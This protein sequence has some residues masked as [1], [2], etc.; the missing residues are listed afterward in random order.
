MS[1]TARAPRVKLVITEE[2]IAAAVPRDSNHCM[3]ADA[4]KVARPDA[5]AVS[6]DLATIRFTDP[7]KGLRYTYMTPRIAQVCL[8]NFDREIKPVP[9]DFVIRSGQVTRS[10]NTRPPKKAMTDK[11]RSQRAASAKKM[12]LKKSRIVQRDATQR[13]VA[14]RVVAGALYP[15]QPSA[16]IVFRTPE[17]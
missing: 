5:K 7:E 14:E 6:V 3:I 8:V 17:L 11:E 12:N 16:A 2:L 1:R 13:I 9:F 15:A 4:L 10:G